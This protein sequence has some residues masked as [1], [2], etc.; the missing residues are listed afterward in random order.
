MLAY[1]WLLIRAAARNLSRNRRRTLLSSLAIALGLAALIFTD[2][3]I[4][5]MV[6]DMVRLATDLMLG[7]AQIHAE[8]FRQEMELERTVREGTTLLRHL[9]EHPSVAHVAP[10]V[11][12]FGMIS[13]P[14][15][16]ASVTV[17]GID[18]RR[19]PPLSQVDEAIIAG[20]YL[21]PH[22]RGRVLLGQ[23]LAET[24]RV[25]V[26][27]RI[28]LTAAQAETGELAMSAYRVGGIF[29]FASREM[30]T[31][32][33]FLPLQDAQEL[34][35][36]GERVHE[37]AIRF[38]DIREADHLSGSFWSEFQTEGN[39]LLNWRQL[40]PELNS[41]L[42]AVDVQM[43]IVGAIL[44]AIVAFGIIN[45][46]F[47]SLYERMFE[48]GVLRAIGT[49]P[50]Q[51][52][53]MILTEAGLLAV[54]SIVL[55]NLLGAA[56]TAA[57]AQIGLDYTGIEYVGIT[58]HEPIRPVLAWSQF[59]RYPI[60]VFLFTLLAAIYPALYAARLRPAKAM[61]RSL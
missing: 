56:V 4:R 12:A 7:H 23:K 59:Y 55:G 41:T 38:W 33:V 20:E 45:T 50:L 44:F 6:A 29:A 46:L 8:G 42:A 60:W 17:Y 49:R 3:L 14:S 19:E 58:F 51:M 9:E 1:W 61:R 57:V 15:N 34:Y 32:L 31:T 47:M 25:Q 37:L 5:G 18:P 35:G 36:L 30:N 43:Y 24:L 53:G 54:V 39:E 2:G 40:M 13:S 11:V 52:A 10:R 28:V 26:G 16:V 21:V 27:D 48:F 22:E